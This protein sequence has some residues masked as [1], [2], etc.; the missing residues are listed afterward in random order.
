MDNLTN[1]FRFR[2][3]PGRVISVDEMMVAFKGRNS[4]IQYI[5]NKPIKRGFKSWACCDANNGYV[6]TLELYTGAV[7]NP[8]LLP[9]GNR[10]V[11]DLT[12]PFHG[13]GYKVVFL[14]FFLSLLSPS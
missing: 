11:K 6:L 2:Y 13:L 8:D 5:P 4:I 12:K 1:S 9:L 7:E 10:V 3:N 14:T